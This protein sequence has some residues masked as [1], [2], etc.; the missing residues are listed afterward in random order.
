MAWAAIPF[1]RVRRRGPRG[2]THPR[3]RHRAGAGRGDEAGPRGDRRRLRL[4]RAGGR[5]GC[6]GPARRQSAARAHARLDPAHRRGAEGPDHDAGRRRVPL[7]QRRSPQGARPL[8]AGSAL[9]DVRRR[10]DEVRRR[11]PDH[12]PGEHR[13]PLRGHRVRGRDG[14]RQRADRVDRAARRQAAPRRRGHLDQAAL[15]L[16]DAPDRRVRVRLR[17]PQRP[18]QG[19]GRPQGEHHEVHRRPLPARRPRGRRREFRHR[20]RRPDR[21]QHVHAARPAA[22]G[23]RRARA[24]E[25]LRRHRLRPRRGHDRR[26]RH[27][28]GRELRRRGVDLRAHARLGAEVRRPEQGQPDGDD[29][30][31]HADA[32]PP[33]GARGGRPARGGD[34]RT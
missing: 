2:D 6:D 16:G 5:R 26:P 20:V 22:G 7:R 21:G 4:G 1:A 24:P 13:G 11:R 10:A 9:Q 14:A 27:G 15:D 29:A 28:A 12:R 32:A 30:L 8:R 3:R 18:P 17:P 34:R 19:H 23:I 25:P 31:G 33:R